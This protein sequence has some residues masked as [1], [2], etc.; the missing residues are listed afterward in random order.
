MQVAVT[1]PLIETRPASDRDE[2]AALLKLAGPLVGA[3][4]LQMA[5]YAIDVVFVA[6]LGTVEFA[7]ATLGVFLYSL[8][9]WALMSMATA[10]APIIAAELGRRRH[11]VREVRRSFRMALWLAGFSALPFGAMLMAGEPILLA[12]GQDPRVA[13]RAGDFLVIIVWALPASLF[14]AVMR[15]VAATLGRP[16]WAMG[17]TAM[18][19]GL[20]LVANWALVF[21]NLGFPALGLEGSAWASV[22]VSVAMML[23]YFA[24]LLLDPVLRRWRLFGRWWRTEWPRMIEILRLGIPIS[25]AV[26]MESALFGGASVL[27]GL[28]GVAEVAAHAIALNIAALAFQ[29]PLGVSQASTIRVGMGYGAKDPAW[30]AR[31]GRVALIVGIGFMVVTAALMWAVPRTLIGI[32][33]DVD[34]A[35]EAA[36]VALA[37]RLLMVGAVFQLVDGAQAVA[38]GVLRGLQDTRVPMLIALF[39]YWVV[40]F[41]ASVLFGFFTGGGAVGIWIGLA[42]GLLVVSA[43]L[44]WRWRARERLGLVPRTT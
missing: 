28:I 7:A 40:G 4:L 27:M 12:A 23:A 22:I 34:V 3:N 21:G 17:V 36:V 8:V 35:S 42:I 18:A 10:C 9:M 37:T 15:T 29:V 31:A 33:I 30:V 6:R 16:G 20:A 11:S 26:T 19:V 41:G 2:L 32:Y 25:L 44:L 14:A 13:A 1:P 43:L 38:A 39:G 5:V 24:I